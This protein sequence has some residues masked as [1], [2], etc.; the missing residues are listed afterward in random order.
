MSFAPCILVPKPDYSKNMTK[1]YSDQPV[2]T[3]EEAW[4]G[5]IFLVFFSKMFP[6]SFGTDP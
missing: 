2:H 6:F 4:P 5:T 3:A 1:L